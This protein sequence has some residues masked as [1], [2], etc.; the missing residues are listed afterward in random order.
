MAAT[1]NLCLLVV[2]GTLSAAHG[3]SISAPS[4][5]NCYESAVE[6]L[7]SGSVFDDCC[8]VSEPSFT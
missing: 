8:Q 3:S 4:C 5:Q 6:K 2:F 7:M 1:L